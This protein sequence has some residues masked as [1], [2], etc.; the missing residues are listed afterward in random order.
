MR[1]SVGRYTREDGY[2]SDKS[3]AHTNKNNTCQNIRNYQL[4]KQDK[5]ISTIRKKDE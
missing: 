1:C 3:N 4:Q 5:G 2:G